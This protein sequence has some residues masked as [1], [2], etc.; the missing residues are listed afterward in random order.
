M[1]RRDVQQEYGAMNKALRRKTA[2]DYP[3]ETAS[4]AGLIAAARVG[5]AFVAAHNRANQSRAAVS[6]DG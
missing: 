4:L 3:A 2:G 1:P 5:C 6:C